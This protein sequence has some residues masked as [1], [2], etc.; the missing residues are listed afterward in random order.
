MGTTITARHGG[1]GLNFRIFLPISLGLH[2][3]V[4]SLVTSFF[5]DWTVLH[6]S[7]PELEV[8]LLPSPVVA[9]N[10]PV[11]KA[12]LT[13]R[14]EPKIEAKKAGEKAAFVKKEEGRPV[15]ERDLEKEDHPPEP[16]HHRIPVE[17]PEPLKPER[18]TVIQEPAAP[19]T[20]IASSS[21]PESQRQQDVQ[22]GNAVLLKTASLGKESVVFVPSSSPSNASKE[23]PVAVPEGNGDGKR[24]GKL[25]LT[26]EREIVPAQPR[27][28]EN[29]RPAYPQ[30]ARKKGLEGEV[31]LK[32]EV[33]AD[34]RVGQVELKRSSGYAILDASAITTVKQWKFIPGKR[35]NDPV[36]LWVHIPV[37]YRLE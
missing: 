25:S 32:V 34:G 8:L 12:A 14:T 2:L 19:K 24:V 15:S 27:Y 1:N 4:F 26:R 22:D 28:A 23:A 11:M 30:E 29:P 6:L 35:G 33:L 21:H 16:D 3:F 9:E 7:S 20:P 18:E 31:L 10:K 13:H 36:A 5:P 37:R 17:E